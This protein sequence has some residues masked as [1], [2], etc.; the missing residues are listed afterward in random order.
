MAPPAGQ[1]RPVRYLGVFALIVVV[2][3]A[4]VFF[5]GNGQ[6]TPKL[7]IDLQGGTRVTLTAISPDG[8]P[9]AQDSLTL[10]KQILSDRVNGNGVTGAEIVQDG[11]NLVITAPGN[12][13]DQLK[14]LGKAAVL[15][16]RPVLT[17]PSSNQP[18]ILP[19]TPP[20]TSGKPSTSNTAK[21]SGTTTPSGTST[22]APATTTSPKPQGAP[23]PMKQAA[24]TTTTNP[25]SSTAASS[26]SAST[27]PPSISGVADPNQAKAIQT[28][29]ALRQNPA[30]A[31][32]QNAQ[33][34][35][36]AALDCSKP[37]PLAGYDDP[38]KPLVTCDTDHQN[39]Y[40]LGASF[41]DGRQIATAQSGFDQQQAKWIVTLTFKPDGAKTWA[42]YTG[43]NVG[44]QAAFT[45][46][47]QVQ[48][49]PK[50]NQQIIGNTEISGSFTQQSAKELANVLSYGSLPLSFTMSENQ[51]VSATLG[52]SSMQAGLLAGGIGLLLVI[53]YCLFYY[54]ALGVLTLLSLVCSG[55]TVYAVLV[56]FGRWINYSLDLPGIAGFIIAIGITADSFVV[57]FE[58]MKDEVREG[59]SFRSAVPRAWVR[60]RRTI[61]SADAVSFLAAAVLYTLAVG[62]VR[63]FAFTT[64]MS[65]VID[66]FVVFLVTHPLVALASRSKTLSKPSFSG[67]GAVQQAGVELRA[68][69]RAA[70][71]AVKEA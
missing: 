17:D 54:R 63:G 40:I 60:A 69:E 20:S 61:L 32:D 44:Q 7:G 27:P 29:K 11:S 64:G 62:D 34:A 58:R 49:A 43:K 59:R 13:G 10:A 36:F 5:T 45:L 47:G 70:N 52:L 33:A 56:L 24:P 25:P 19:A 68:A 67:L 55:L 66:L 57:F 12:D 28:A 3:Y 6:P 48:S 65:T 4:L 31:T 38:D 18:M 50:I 14:A 22:S 41:L 51:T 30:V 53:V 23:V 35:A 1:I 2:L 37:D 9:P 26:T 39:K 21:P 42:D 71:P 16:F 15:R 46:D 8:K